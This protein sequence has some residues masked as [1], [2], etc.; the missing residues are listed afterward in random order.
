MVVT[1]TNQDRH[2][3]LGLAVKLQQRELISPHSDAL[4]YC[5]H[6]A[7]AARDRLAQASAVCLVDA[8]LAAWSEPIAEWFRR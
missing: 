5:S 4:G 6:F 8:V 7:Q 3:A 2:A 1:T